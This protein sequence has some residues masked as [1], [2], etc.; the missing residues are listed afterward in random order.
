MINSKKCE[1]CGKEKPADDFSKSYKNRCKGC[2]A[3]M[4]RL[5]REMKNLRNGSSYKNDEYKKLIEDHSKNEDNLLIDWEQRRF[6]LVK[7]IVS[8]LEVNSQSTIES[9]CDLAFQI[10][11]KIIKRLKNTNQHDE[12]GIQDPQDH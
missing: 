1:V 11:D 6:D 3:S 9:D 12:Q 4:Q 10:A 5:N 2:V 7:S 8:A